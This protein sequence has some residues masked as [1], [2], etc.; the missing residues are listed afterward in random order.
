MA[1]KVKR[2]DGLTA[3]RSVLQGCSL[4]EKK[5]PKGL[6]TS[7]RR[8]MQQMRTKMP[9]IILRTQKRE[10]TLAPRFNVFHA[11]GIE[12]RE[13]ILHTPFLA[14]LLNPA[15]THSQG[16]L[17]LN[18]FF[19]VMARQHEFVCPIKT[20]RNMW[21][22]SSEVYI[23]RY[24]VIDMLIE[25]PSQKYVLV[26][27]NKISA[28]E[29]HKQISDYAT[30]MTRNYPDYKTRQIALLTLDG[31]S[32]T[33]ARINHHCFTI[34]YSD[35]IKQFLEAVLDGI[36]AASVKLAV[37]QYLGTIKK[38]TKDDYDDINER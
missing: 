6:P 18:K 15:E 19:E 7:V 21:Q 12:R 20:G 36:K 33:T 26:V 37:S 38:I 32:A 23:G 29:R 1:P 10:E 2:L 13:A 25:C 16:T 24:G 17:F 22:I 3:V 9:R 5:R 8:L 4:I 34:S 30:W 11:L 14:Y 31:H 28:L 27:E 35:H